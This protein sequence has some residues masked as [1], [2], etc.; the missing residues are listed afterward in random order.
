MQNAFIK[1]A[2]RIGSKIRRATLLRYRRKTRDP[3][4]R[5]GETR[6]LVH[7]G[8]HKV[9]S[10]WFARVLGGIADHYGL[11]FQNCEQS[12]L[13][14]DTDIFMQQHSYI[15][16]TELPQLAGS[17]LIRDPRDMIESGY[18]SSLDE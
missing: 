4:R 16:M 3:F 6:F 9:G 7:C 13:A 14:P 11:R 18:L 17:H 15:D 5:D 8:Y 2:A 1:T 10:Y 12:Q